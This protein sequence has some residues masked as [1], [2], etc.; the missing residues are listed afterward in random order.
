MFFLISSLENY[1][2]NNTTQHETT[3]DNTSTTW[4]NTRQHEYN[5]KQY[6]CNTRQQ[7]YNKSS[8]RVQNNITFILIYLYHRCILGA[9]YIEIYSSVYVVILRKIKIFFFSNSQNRARKSQGSGLLQLCRNF[10]PFC[11]F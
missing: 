11:L 6:E 2:S 9:R 3:R 1:T 10:L 5:T 4:H 7:E 8:T